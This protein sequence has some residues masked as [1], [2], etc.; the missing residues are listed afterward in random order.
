M[1]A[2]ML[3]NVARKQVAL[4][5]SPGR[6]RSPSDRDDAEAVE[7]I[8]RDDGFRRDHQR[9]LSV[10]LSAANTAKSAKA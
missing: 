9:R 1:N 8:E 4:A 5:A 3:R 2:P 7:P 6:T 10:R